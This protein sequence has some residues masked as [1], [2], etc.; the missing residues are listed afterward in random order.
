MSFRNRPRFLCDVDD[1]LANYVQGFVSAVIATG[2][3]PGLSQ[4]H[5]FDEWDLSKSLKLT[6]E[7][8]DKVYSLIN[9][10]G[11]ATMLNPL[12]GAVEGVT[13]IME[14]ADVF[15]LTSPLKSSPTWSYD[16]RLWLEKL[17]EDA[18]IVSTSEKHTVDGDFLCDDKPV[19]CEEWQAE[20]P[21]GMSL[22]WATG[23]NEGQLPLGVALVGNW[24]LV[25]KLVE[26]R[27]KAMAAGM[28]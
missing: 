28:K 27:A 22:M 13:K 26:V 6:D 17:F 4:N 16:R 25:Y 5:K 11:F 9:M 3:R 19:H 1:V 20:H 24:P 23:R 10:P 18:K 8:D 2:V 14:I 7:E 21:M 12:P 15:F